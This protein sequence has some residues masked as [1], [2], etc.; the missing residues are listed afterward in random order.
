VLIHLSTYK[1]IPDL[2]LRLENM[3]LYSHIQ[4]KHPLSNPVISV[5]INLLSA[6]KNSTKEERVML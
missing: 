5:T 4:E 1:T 2:T 6:L 3:T